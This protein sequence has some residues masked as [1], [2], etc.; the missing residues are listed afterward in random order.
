MIF[1]DSLT[2]QFM[3]M[4]LLGLVSM[5]LI[6][7]QKPFK[8]SNVA[9]MGHEVVI[10]LIMYHMFCFTEFVPDPKVR[11]WIGYSVILITALHLFVFYFLTLRKKVRGFLRERK[12]K[13]IMSKSRTNVQHREMKNA[14]KAHNR[15]RRELLAL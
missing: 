4:I 9:E 8:H 6:G 1:K 3:A 14:I 5:I 12:N 11:S 2:T 7:V 15:E 13:S 10:I